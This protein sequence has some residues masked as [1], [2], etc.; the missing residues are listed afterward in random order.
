MESVG[1]FL[2]QTRQQR[3]IALEQLASGTKI[4]LRML[5][6]LEANDFQQIPSEV[7]ARGFI[8][9]YARFLGIDE[10][11]ILKKFQESASQFYVKT[12]PIEVHQDSP[13]QRVS[14]PRGW[15]KLIVSGAVSGLVVFVGVALYKQFTL[16]PELPVQETVLTPAIATRQEDPPHQADGIEIAVVERQ[17]VVKPMTLPVEFTVNVPGIPPAQAG[18]PSVP[19]L[20]A[21]PAPGLGDL[22]L[23]VEATDRS[24][25]MAHIDDRLVKEVL[26]Q[27]GEKVRW[28]AKTK[29]VL[30]LGNAGGVRLQFNGKTLN[31]LGPQGKVVK[32]II[33]MR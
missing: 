17:Q 16:S 5:R 2:R 27:P 26:L 11:H 25:V 12:S 4:S 7:V 22:T 1:D 9:S 18:V 6:A 13:S 32:N 15:P 33:L 3:G 28:Q 23:L 24:W 30:T 31:A 10:E 29:F 8:R 14:R 21:Q 19:T 20:Q